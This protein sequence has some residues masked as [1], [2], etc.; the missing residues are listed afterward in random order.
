[1]IRCTP[2]KVSTR[3]KVGQKRTAIDTRSVIG[4]SLVGQPICTLE[5]ISIHYTRSHLDPDLLVTGNPIFSES[6]ALDQRY[7]L[8]AVLYA[9][10][11]TGERPQTCAVVVVED[12]TSAVPISHGS[13][14]RTVYTVSAEQYQQYSIAIAIDDD[15]GEDDLRDLAHSPTHYNISHFN[16]TSVQCMCNPGYTGQNCENKYIPCDPSPC[17]ND[18]LCRQVDSLSYEC[19]CPPGVYHIQ[20][21]NNIFIHHVGRLTYSR[22]F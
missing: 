3:M 13:A 16:I 18:G 10:D 4:V 7:L 15:D 1:M 21:T 11:I 17:L 14:G 12:L 9:R 20:T 22:H 8:A 19:Q 6:D 5:K 2:E